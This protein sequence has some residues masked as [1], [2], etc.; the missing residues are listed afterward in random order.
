MSV[1]VK[2]VENAMLC[3]SRQCWEAGIAAQALLEKGDEEKLRLMV[4]DMVLRQST[5]GRLCNVENTPAITDSSFCMPAVYAVAI[6]EK[7]EKY[8]NAV[9]DNAQLFLNTEDRAEDGTLYH[10]RGTKQ[11]WADSAAF[12]PYALAL[13][14]SPK[15]GVQQMEGI[16][17]RLYHEESGLYYHMWDEES[18]T[19]LRPLA[20]GIG[21]GWI[22]TGLLR[23]GLE[24]DSSHE[25]DK[26]ELFAEFRR[27]LD[28]MLSLETEKHGFHDILDDPS[29][30][31]EAETAAMVAYVIYRGVKEGILAREYMERADWIRM[32][33]YQRV[34]F[35]GLVMGASSSPDF[36]RSGTSVEAQA[37][38]LLMETVYREAMGKQ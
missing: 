13:T 30:F 1:Y 11:I 10:M 34:S 31:E 8:L 26:E 3:M 23:L 9:M 32:A 7:N 37:H 28:R 5:D 38:F 17:R 33:L 24:L 2:A 35:E 4:Y 14:G 12:L 21:N 19:F 27:L 18:K 25:K 16:R 15:E 36:L 29:T 20:W 22:L 6:R